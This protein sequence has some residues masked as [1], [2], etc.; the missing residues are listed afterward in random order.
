MI[1]NYELWIKG[2]DAADEYKALD[3]TIDKDTRTYSYAVATL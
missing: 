3:E 1:L 2:K